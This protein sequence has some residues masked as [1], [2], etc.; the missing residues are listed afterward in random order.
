[1]W[2][3]ASTGDPFIQSGD[4]RSETLYVIFVDRQLPSPAP[5]DAIGED[6]LLSQVLVRIHRISPGL[7][8]KGP[9]SFSRAL[10]EAE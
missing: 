5:H 3:K 9:R 1:L 10:L 4:Q 7:K 8:R 2:E 6:A